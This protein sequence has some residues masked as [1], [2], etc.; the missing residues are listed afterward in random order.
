LSST[1]TLHLLLLSLVLSW[2]EDLFTTGSGV[3]VDAVV[4]V[5]HL[6]SKEIKE[7]RLISISVTSSFSSGISFLLHFLFFV[8]FEISVQKSESGYDE[9][10][11]EVDNFESKVSLELEVFPFGSDLIIWSFC[12]FTNNFFDNNWRSSSNSSNW[13]SCWHNR[14]RC[15][16]G[17]NSNWSSNN[18]SMWNLLSW[19]SSFP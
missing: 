18:L 2:S 7:S 13:C 16:R 11:E 17:S 14:N 15:W 12:G 4:W 6:T 10:D 19:M 9:E 8:N 5:V 3:W 1:E